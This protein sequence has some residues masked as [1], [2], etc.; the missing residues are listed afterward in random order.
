[1]VR[2]KFGGDINVGFLAIL[3]LQIRGF[4]NTDRI[5]MVVI[6]WWESDK[7]CREYKNENRVEI[8]LV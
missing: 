5:F 4:F 8:W 2:W 6:F 3:E 1:M 7:K